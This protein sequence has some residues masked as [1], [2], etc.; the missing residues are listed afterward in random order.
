MRQKLGT[1]DSLSH[2]RHEEGL[3]VEQALLFFLTDMFL[4]NFTGK[5]VTLCNKYLLYIS[6]DSLSSLVVSNNVAI[7]YPMSNKGG[8]GPTR[9]D[10]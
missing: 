4:L 8:R 2:F 9:A 1:L 10:W 3:D 7:I 5:N 6:Y